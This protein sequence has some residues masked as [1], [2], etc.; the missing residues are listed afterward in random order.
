[1]YYP[2]LRRNVVHET[3][4]IVLGTARLTTILSTVAMR[5]LI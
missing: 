4:Q 1:M 2:Q 5:H 3:R